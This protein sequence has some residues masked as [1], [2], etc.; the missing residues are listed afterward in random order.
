MKI[1]EPDALETRPYRLAGQLVRARFQHACT[2]LPN[3][4]EE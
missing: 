3:R 2:T 4:S 1:Q